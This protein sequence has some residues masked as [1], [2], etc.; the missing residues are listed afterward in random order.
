[1]GISLPAC[2]FIWPGLIECGQPV[3]HVCFLIRI[4]AMMWGD[5]RKKETPQMIRIC[6]TEI[7]EKLNSTV[8]GNRKTRKDTKLNGRAKPSKIGR[9]EW[10]VFILIRRG[11]AVK[12]GLNTNLHLSESFPAS[13]VWNLPVTSGN[14]L[15]EGISKGDNI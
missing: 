1:M 11:C 9:M 5:M 14:L 7:R 13:H 10:S 3:S 2:W 15:A 8:E 12:H 4:K 6:N